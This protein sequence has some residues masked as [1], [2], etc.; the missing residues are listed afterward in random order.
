[1]SKFLL[2][3]FGVWLVDAGYW[4]FADGRLLLAFGRKKQPAYF[5]LLQK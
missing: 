4:L 1:M 3:A 2:L 5:V